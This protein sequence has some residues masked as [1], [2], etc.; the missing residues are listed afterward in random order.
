MLCV[1]LKDPRAK[2]LLMEIRTTREKIS[3]HIV[4]VF[5]WCRYSYMVADAITR[6]KPNISLTKFREESKLKDFSQNLPPLA[7]FDA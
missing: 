1:L 6:P 3:E 2:S 5:A 7:I 4:G